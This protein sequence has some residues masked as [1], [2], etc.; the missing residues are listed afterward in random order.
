MKPPPTVRIRNRLTQ[1]WRERAVTLKAVSFAAVGLLNTFLDLGIFLIGYNL[2]QLP[3]VVANV[4]AW[5]VAVTFSYAANSY[6]TFAVESGRKLRWRSYGAFVASGL[7][8]VTANTATL[9]V[10]SQWMPVL[11]AK[12]LAIA[13]SFLVNFS[14]SHFVVFRPSRGEV[15]TRIK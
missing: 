2:L 15:E 10:A 4:L 12:L 5:L 6:T 8:G 7:A 13:V 3:L 11:S 14:L 1:A 9:V